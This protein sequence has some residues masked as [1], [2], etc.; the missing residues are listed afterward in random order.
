MDVT[1]IGPTEHS[2]D[3]FVMAYDANQYPFSGKII[4]PVSTERSSKYIPLRLK[5]TVAPAANLELVCHT[6]YWR[7]WRFAAPSGQIVDW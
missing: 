7:R 2:T 5:F 1:A 3:K 4:G 6:L